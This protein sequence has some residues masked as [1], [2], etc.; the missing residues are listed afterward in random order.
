MAG[1]THI[2]AQATHIDVE[3]VFAAPQHAVA[4]T[5][6]M[7]LPATVGEVLR[8]AAASAEFA[9]IDVE[10]C[11]IGVFGRV[12]APGQPLSDGDRVELYRPLAADPKAARRARARSD[13]PGRVSPRPR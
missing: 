12:V 4:K 9:Q 6:R 3:V 5:F 10:H 1:D 8:A 2:D 13:R 7:A 11:A